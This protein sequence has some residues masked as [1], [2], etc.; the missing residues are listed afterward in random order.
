LSKFVAISS[1][2]G[3]SVGYKLTLLLEAVE[4][5]KQLPSLEY[6]PIA[7]VTEKEGLSQTAITKSPEQ[8]WVKSKPAWGKHFHC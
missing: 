2:G 6:P 7:Y 8:A 5:P 3:E 1:A 4:G